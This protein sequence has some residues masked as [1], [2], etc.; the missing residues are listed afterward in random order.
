MAKPRKIAVS[1]TVTVDPDAWELTYG[2]FTPADVR[3]YVLEQVQGSAASLE[4]CI[5][6]VAVKGIWH[7]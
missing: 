7:G 1:V 6:D 4:E 2:E 5:V 3:S